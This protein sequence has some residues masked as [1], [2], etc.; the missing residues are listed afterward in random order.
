MRH[1]PH[2][3]TF[4]VNNFVKNSISTPIFNQKHDSLTHQ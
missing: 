4:S 1:C 3:F 2:L